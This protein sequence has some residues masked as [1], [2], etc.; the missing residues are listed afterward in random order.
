MALG[1]SASILCS[2]IVYSFNCFSNS[3]IL[4]SLIL[5]SSLSLVF[6]SLKITSLSRIS[7]MCF[8]VG[9]L[10]SCS[11]LS[12]SDNRLIYA[13]RSVMMISYFLL[14]LAS[15][16]LIHRFMDPSNSEIIDPALLQRLVKFGVSYCC[17]SYCFLLGEFLLQVMQSIT[18]S[19]N[20]L[21]PV[22]CVKFQGC[23]DMGLL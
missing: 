22:I 4:L 13:W 16:Y 1:C 17:C 2:A 7:E 15:L 19:R 20:R 6:S 11:N 3:T 23:S 21:L 18:V 8:L 12:F 9:D 10:A 14:V 5:I